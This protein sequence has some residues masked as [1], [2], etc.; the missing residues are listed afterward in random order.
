MD[1]RIP[2]RDDGGGASPAQLRLVRAEEKNAHPSLAK[3]ASDFAA[4]K[5]HA[6]KFLAASETQPAA[7]PAVQAVKALDVHAAST[8][9]AATRDYVR[10]LH[11]FSQKLLDAGDALFARF[12]NDLSP[13]AAAKGDALYQ[14]LGGYAAF[15]HRVD[16]QTYS[17]QMLAIK[18]AA[19]P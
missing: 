15:E 7:T 11:P 3:L 17:D 14:R 12:T 19:N 5:T 18:K 4:A 10:G 6:Q 1:D 8:L 16:F 2:G 9:V 13:Q